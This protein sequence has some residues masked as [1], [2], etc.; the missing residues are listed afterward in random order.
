M[1]RRG[2]GSAFSGM[3]TLNRNRRLLWF[4]LVAGLVLAGNAIGEGALWYI[5]R[6][7][8]PDIILLYVQDFLLGFAT[9]FCLVFLLAG[10]VLGISSKRDAPASFFTGLCEA[11]KYV[12]TLIV[13]SFVLVLAVMLLDRIYV[14][15]TMLF[16]HELAFLYTLGD[17]FF[18]STITQFPFNWTLDWNMLTEIPGYG[19]R[20][21]LLLVY[22]FGFL[23]TLHFLAI[24][25]VLFVLTPF[26]VPLIVLEKKSL[27][28]AVAGS[29]ALL[30]KTWAGVVTC[31][32]FL[33]VIIT[34]VFLTHL[35]I[36]AASGIVDP[37][38]T[39]IFHPPGMWIAFA[40]L[41]NIAL[42]IVAFVV[43]TIGGIAVRD[44]YISAK[45]RQMPGS[46][47]MDPL[48]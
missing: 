38:Q 6:N 20:S 47:G 10:L 25:L 28:E 8:Q 22:P 26:V 39:V 2:I 36:Q 15:L 37:Y 44:L 23:E 7:I 1:I 32:L 45:T 43:A 16:P 21:L 5:N 40:L 27:T 3:R 41:Y 33:G 34:G 30:K 18:V 48:H 17:G 46:A 29:F 35:L 42:L 13:W 31:A 12:K 24:I 19:G 11:K 9:L 4:T 14:Y